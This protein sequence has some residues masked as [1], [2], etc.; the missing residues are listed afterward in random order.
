[1]NKKNAPRTLPHGYFPLRIHAATGMAQR[2]VD[3][4]GSAY[5]VAIISPPT[6]A[7]PGIEETVIAVPFPMKE[8]VRIDFNIFASEM[9][10][11]EGVRTEFH[12]ESA[13]S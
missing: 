12:M 9:E 13:Y 10:A 4:I 8:T 3:T 11:E 5:D 7:S 6:S 2:F 1:M